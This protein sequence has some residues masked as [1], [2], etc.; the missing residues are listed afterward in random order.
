MITRERIVQLVKER[1]DWEV[2]EE[3]PPK[4][5]KDY[6]FYCIDKE[7]YKYKTT[8]HNLYNKNGCHMV[9]KNNKYS[10]ENIQRFLDLHNIP[11]ELLDREYHT[12]E[13]KMTYRCK[14]CG[15][16]I[17]S[18]WTSVNKYKPDGTKG[19]ITCPNCDGRLESMQAIVL[20]QMFM[21]EY[22]DTIPEECSCINPNT[23]CIMPTDIVNHRL[24][25]A[26]EIQSQWHDNRKDRDEIKR[27]YWINRGYEFYS[28]DI[29]QY[30]VLEMVKLF[31]DVDEIPDYV[32]MN[33]SNKLNYKTIQSMLNQYISPNEISE[34]LDIKVHRIYDAIG[35]GDL[36]YA[37]DYPT[38]GREPIVCFDMDMNKIG[39]FNS[40]TDGAKSVCV[41]ACNV[42]SSL[43]HGKNYSSGYYWQRIEDYNNG[44]EL[45]PTRLKML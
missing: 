13:T 8:P 35:R 11:F 17:K 41:P 2:I 5:D 44:I 45:I 40:I 24:K 6:Q 22:P 37:K 3:L 38:C 16:E 36:C 26:I 14:R 27:S 4:I 30:N 15:E 23:N 34:R 43:Q 42:V 29:R 12:N 7:G 39:V 9:H 33:I 28:P 31:F 25:I 32:N 19:S 21:H 10:I 18:R 20:K 1:R